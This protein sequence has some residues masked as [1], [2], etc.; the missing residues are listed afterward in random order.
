MS[1]NEV[2]F[3]QEPRKPTKIKLGT[4]TDEMGNCNPSDKSACNTK[5][6]HTHLENNFSHPKIAKLQK[7]TFAK[8]FLDKEKHYDTYQKIT[9]IL[10]NR[11]KL[12]DEMNIRFRTA[13]PLEK[14]T[15]VLVTNQQ[16]IEGI[17]KKL[18]P[19]KTGPYLIVDKASE[20]TYILKDNNK[21]QITI[22]RNQ[23]YHIIKLY[24]N[25]QKKSTSN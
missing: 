22:H 25:I 1:P 23:L 8:W 2:V 12:T 6:T 3:S 24:H 7:G 16:Q 5:P 11:K 18:L 14:N 4:T 15:F 21:E 17:S 19:L 13:K 20:T 9:K 10:Q